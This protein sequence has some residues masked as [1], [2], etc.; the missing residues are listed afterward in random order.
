MKFNQNLK[1]VSPLRRSTAKAFFHL[2]VHA[3]GD[4]QSPLLIGAIADYF[5]G[6]YGLGK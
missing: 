6:Q 3:L 5:K 4:A 2:V 1:V